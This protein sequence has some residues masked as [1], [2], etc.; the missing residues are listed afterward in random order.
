MYRFLLTPR[1]IA[2]HLLVIAGIVLM[3]NLGFWQLRRLDER[4]AFNA[5]VTSRIDVPPAPLDDVLGR[6]RPRRRRVALGR[7]DRRLPA[8]RGA[9]ASSTAPRAASPATSSSR[10]CSSRT[11]GSSSSS[12]ASCR[13]AAEAAAPPSGPVEVVGRLRPSQERRRGQLSDPSTGDLTEVQRLDIDRLARQLPGQPVADVRRV[14][15]VGPGR[16]RAVP[17]AARPCPSSAR[18][19]T[20]PTP[21]S[22]SSSPPPSPSAGCSPCASRSTPGERVH[23]QAPPHRPGSPPQQRRHRPA[24]LRRR[25]VEAQVRR[26]ASPPAARRRRR[27]TPPARP[28]SSRRSTSRP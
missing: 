24:D 16:G 25:G 9:R 26:P 5:Q 13:S 1:W 10:R 28:A 21:C 18:A 19:P 17:A 2:F 14:D 4:Q 27:R 20:S 8:R 23:H 12:G 15:V 6:R 7:G 11:A 22:G 3:I